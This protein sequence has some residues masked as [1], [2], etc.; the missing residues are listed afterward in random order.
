M[1]E[2]VQTTYLQGRSRALGPF[3]PS[4]ERTEK[5]W[6]ASL[7]SRIGE[8]DPFSRTRHHTVSCGSTCGCVTVLAL[9][10]D[11]GGS[12]VRDYGAVGCDG[13]PSVRGP[14]SPGLRARTMD[15]AQDLMALRGS[16][17]AYNFD[18][19]LCFGRL[20]GDHD[21]RFEGFCWSKTLWRH[22]KG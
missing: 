18:C 1:N 9:E 21:D 19:R 22:R 8:S 16:S 17:H 14:P 20:I 11:G 13:T 7:Y 3:H 5:K 2:P 6:F 12:I 4:C 10:D 15:V